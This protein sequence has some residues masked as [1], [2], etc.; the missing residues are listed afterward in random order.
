MCSLRSDRM[1]VGGGPSGLNCGSVRGLPVFDCSR[2]VSSD[3]FPEGLEEKYLSAAHRELCFSPAQF[4][5]S[6]VSESCDLGN[7]ARVDEEA[8]MDVI[9][10]AESEE[11]RRWWRQVMGVA[12]ASEHGEG[13]EAAERTTRGLSA[14]ARM[15]VSAVRSSQ[16]PSAAA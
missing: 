16:G 8:V 14:M 12:P 2:W 6:D 13:V 10:W 1:D 15:R 3:L 7:K 5:V 4:R 11:R 9:V